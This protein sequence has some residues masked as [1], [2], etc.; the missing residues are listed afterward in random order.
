M[1]TVQ[2]A[3]E[4]ID[5]EKSV[6][7]QKKVPLTKTLGENLAE[8]VFAERN[9]PPFDRVAMDGIAL[10]FQAWKEKKVDSFPI[11]GIQA[12]GVPALK[13]E[14]SKSCIEVMTGSTLPVGC[15]CVV[16]YEQISLKQGTATLEKGLEII[17]G[18][19]IHQKGSDYKEGDLLLEKGKKINSP[20]MGVLAS[21]GRTQV[22]I[23]EALNV[24]IVSTGDELVPIQ[25]TPLSHQIRLSNP[26]ALKAELKRSLQKDVD[27]F[28]L[29]DDPKDIF[30]ALEDIIE[31]YQVVIITGGVSKGKYDY[32]PSVLAD[33][34][35]KEIFHKVKQRPGKPFWFGKKADGPHIFGLPGNPVSCLVCLRRY[36]VPFLKNSKESPQKVVLQEDFSFNKNLTLFMPVTV[37]GNVNGKLEASLKKTNG[38]GDYYSLAKSDGFIELPQEKNKFFQGETFSFYPWS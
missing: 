4:L 12:A 23:E 27:I 13:L 33:L 7:K 32:V 31:K 21:E 30:S 29:K 3:Q 6:P 34:G 17:Q 36:V 15:D 28:H 35:V 18:Q 11:K 14:D 2:K 20:L 5:N 37:Q 8:E 24:A 19:N 26:H 1:I 25:E 10:S 38:S 16:P 22:T 9:Q